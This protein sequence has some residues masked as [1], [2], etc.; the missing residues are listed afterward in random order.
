MSVMA[1][2][3]EIGVIQP[4]QEI[5][6]LCRANKV[7][8]HTDAA[9]AVGKI[10]IDVN[11]MKIDLLSISGHKLYGPKGRT[12]HVFVLSNILAILFALLKLCVMKFYC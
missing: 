11:K 2:N 9:Q 8:F 4:L 7:F 1:V 6:E 10:D 3:N 5:G 12:A